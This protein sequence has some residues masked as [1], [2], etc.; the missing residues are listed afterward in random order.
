M[1]TRRLKP[2]FGEWCIVIGLIGLVVAAVR[3][4]VSQAMEER[5]LIDLVARLHEVRSAV[6]VYKAD[7]AGL[8]PGQQ[9]F[10]GNVD[11]EAFVHAL[12]ATDPPRQRP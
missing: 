11:P 7:H 6:A 10:G 8:Y 12:T 2:T 9:Y 4:G 5:R 1:E 3:P